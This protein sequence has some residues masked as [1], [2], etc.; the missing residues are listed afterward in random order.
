MKEK[1][2]YDFSI[3][4]RLRKKEGL[5]IEDLSKSSGISTAVISKLERNQT[6]PDLKTI[7]KISEALY[8]KASDLIALAESFDT[9][10]KN[11]SEHLSGDFR[12]KE[13]RYD[14]IRMLLGTAPK[15]GK[16]SKQ[17]IHKDDHEICWVLKGKLLIELT[18]KRYELNEGESIKFDA[19]LK[20]TYEALED[21]ELL[22]IHR[23]KE[24]NIKV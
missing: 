24:K 14:N 11:S 7:Y 2:I 3:L 12:F 18:D 23:K 16:V 5:N 15:G 6:L 8:I 1:K 22:I 21:S 13:V 17:K 20:H 4:R 10:R 9:E 19:L